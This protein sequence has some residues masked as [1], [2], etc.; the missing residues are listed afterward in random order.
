MSNVH[1]G[2]SDVVLGLQAVQLGVVIVLQVTKLKS[3]VF[4]QLLELRSAFFLQLLEHKFM[5]IILLIQ[6]LSVLRL[7]RCQV[8]IIEPILLCVLFKTLSSNGVNLITFGFEL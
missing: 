2:Q 4:L 3:I 6:F 7:H 1:L 5:L 8:S